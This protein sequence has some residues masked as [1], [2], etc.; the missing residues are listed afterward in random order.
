MGILRTGKHHRAYR[1]MAG[2]PHAVFAV[3]NLVRQHGIEVDGIDASRVQTIYNGLDLADW[4]AAGSG[5]RLSGECLITTAGNIR[6]VKGHDVFVRAAALVVQQFPDATFSIAGEVLEP[7]YYEE[8]QALVQKLGL[9]GRFRFAGGVSDLRGHLSRADVFVLPSRSEGFS[10]AIV[11][12][13]AAGLPVVATDVG[14]NA[15]A[16]S[17]GV[18][19]FIV[20]SEDPEAL[21]AAI[22]SLTVDPERAKAMG[23]AGREL[24]ALQFTTEAMMSRTTQAYRKRI[25]KKKKVK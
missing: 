6:H 5:A 3:S 24:A 23:A 25:A 14:G 2:L 10:N 17:D 21:A 16:V 18:T 20:P 15:E 1:L 8:L 12:A 7:A 22:L 11:E 4:M 19:G 9:S 13:M